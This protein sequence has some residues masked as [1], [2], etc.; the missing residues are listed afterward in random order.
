MPIYG[1]V[2]A[3]CGHQFETLVMTGETA[4]CPACASTKLDQQL[5]LIAKPAKGG[6]DPVPMCDGAGG[7]G[8]CSLEP[9]H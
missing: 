1:Y 7:C 2:C 3:S 6:S 5:S 4:S 8:R 9:C